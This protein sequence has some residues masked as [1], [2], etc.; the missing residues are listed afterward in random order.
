VI[1]I[2]G[3]YQMLGR[4]VSDPEA[5]ESTAGSAE[6]L[7]L[8]PI[9]TVI[10]RDKRTEAVR[11]RTRQGVSFGAYAIHAGRT[12]STEPVGDDWFATLDDGTVD[13]VRR[14]RVLGTYLHGAFESPAV[15]REVFGVPPPA[16]LKQASWDRLADWLEAHLRRRDRLG[17]PL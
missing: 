17:L 16:D 5:V 11:A 1:G 12:T 2:C 7:S 4:R 14:G 15:C 9:E 10:T 6:G 8:L 13:G 3:G